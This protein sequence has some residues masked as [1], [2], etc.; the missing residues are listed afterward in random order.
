MRRERVHHPASTAER[1]EAPHVIGV[2]IAAAAFAV[3]ASASA[4]Q[5]T[6][7]GAV[8]TTLYGPGGGSA[9]RGDNGIDVMFYI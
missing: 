9:W 8:Y 7:C 2:L 5:S 1:D 6:T 4:S 3:P